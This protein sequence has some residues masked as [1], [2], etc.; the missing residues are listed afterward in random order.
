[1]AL[2]LFTRSR[3]V[4][5]PWFVTAYVGDALW[6]WLVFLGIG[7]IWLRWPTS[8]VAVGA[9][10]FA[11]AIEF[12]QLYHAPCLDALRSNRLA[13]LVLGQGFLWSDLVCYLV[14]IT[15]GAIFERHYLLRSAS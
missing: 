8:K 11:L 3:I 2:G 9:L 1:M 14:G 10:L 5:W 12:S 4:H 7:W 13:A 15:I 6:A